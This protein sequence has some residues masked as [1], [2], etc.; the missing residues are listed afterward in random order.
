MQEINEVYLQK[1]K[2]DDIYNAFITV[3]KAENT[4]V[5]TLN[6]SLKGLP[7]AIKDN[8]M[9]KGIRTTNASRITETF[10]PTYDATIV[11]KLKQAGLVVVG[12]TNMDEFAMGSTNETSAFGP[13]HN[14][15][16]KGYVPGGS[17]GGSA[18]AVASGL[19]P[20]AIG[21]DTGGSI[22]QPAAFTGIYGMK[23]T[24]GR[25]SRY[26]ITA[27]ASSLDQAGPLTH[28]LSSNIELLKIL[29]GEDP[30]DSTTSSHPNDI[31]MY[32]GQSIEGLKIG[33]VKEMV[34]PKIID[35]EVLEAF[36]HTCDI[37]R[38]LGAQVEE[39]SIPKTPYALTLYMI[40]AYA[41]ASSN[42]SRFDGIQYGPR[43]TGDDVHSIFENTRKLFGREVK[44]R[45]L[46]GTYV[47]SSENFE[48][49]FIQAQR[50]RT[51]LI[52]EFE[53][54]F[55]T[56]DVLVSPT[57]PT[58]AFPIGEEQ[59]PIKAYSA[60][61]L[62][63]P[64][65]MTGIPALSVPCGRSKTTQLPVGFQIMAGAFEEKRIYQVADALQ[66]A[67]AFEC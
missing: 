47:L 19:V 30:M 15:L 62:T 59:D 56:Y 67:G 23:P 8:I 5:Q 66:K 1:L 48:S 40:L 43:I 65:N 45:I 37:L 16:L 29:I 63:I 64:A 38:S 26:G 53:K 46:T 50:V 24:Y 57:T 32:V 44:Q 3:E 9:T 25:V 31:D 28:N 27:F 36:E 4:E 42:L 33:I 39:V 6:S 14:P 12:K 20:L 21:T 61:I 35:A 17:S 13:V 49:W 55:E 41:E 58:T 51:Q 52:Q 18:A 2:T 11:R 7:I 22:R 60:D 34:D 10:V 54:T